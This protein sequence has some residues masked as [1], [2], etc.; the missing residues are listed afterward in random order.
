MIQS[1]LG[2]YPYAPLKMLLVDPHRLIAG[3]TAQAA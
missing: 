3:P 1:L 2:L